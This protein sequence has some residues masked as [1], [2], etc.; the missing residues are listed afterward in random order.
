M[1]ADRPG[2]GSRGPEMPAHLANEVRAFLEAHGCDMAVVER[3]LD[4]L[5][6]E[7][8]AAADALEAGYPLDTLDDYLND[9]DARQLI[10]ET[11]SA[12]PRAAAAVA[13]RLESAD[14]RARAKLVPGGRCLWGDRI[15]ERR[16]WEAAREW[17]YFMRPSAPGP[18]L[19]RD[20]G[21]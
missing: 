20:L 6:G 3:G 4:G 1:S 14:R 8:E 12:V 15:A 17:W 18:G 7:W 10:H 21:R 2:N 5:I 9:M 13:A 16:G 11:L 19:A